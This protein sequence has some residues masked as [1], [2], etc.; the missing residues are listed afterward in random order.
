MTVPVLLALTKQYPD[1]KI[2]M[3]SKTFFAPLFASIPNVCFLEA[4]VDGRHKGIFGLLRL[5]A[6]LKKTGVNAIADL[7]N[8][9]RSNV[10]TALFSLKGFPTAT[11][12]KAR[13]EK[14][15]LTRTRNKIFTP[16]LPIVERHAKVFA[17]LG[18]PVTI[19]THSLTTMPLAGEVLNLTGDKAHHWIG[20]APFAKHESKVYPNDLMQK[21]IKAL[22]DDLNNKIFLFGAGSHEIDILNKCASDFA[23][24]TVVAGKLK[25]EEELQLISHLDVMLSMDSGNAHL[26]ANYG[27]PV[28]TL[29]GATHPFA[30]FAPFGQPL[31]NALLADREKYP[32]LPTSVYGNKKIEGYQNVMQTI[33]PETVIHK[34]RSVLKKHSI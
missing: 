2:T 28:I 5:Y 12:D 20:I 26:A 22:A 8:V 34:V 21:V 24:S 27:I 15:A 33:S 31:E 32:M 16:L 19:G 4:D 11:V 23:N 3:V 17:D 10:I 7:H 13:A 29:W 1:I 18:L 30:G 25:F 14:K 6:D 9:I